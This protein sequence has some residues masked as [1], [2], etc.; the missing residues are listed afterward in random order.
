MIGLSFLVLIAAAGVVFTAVQLP[1]LLR[2]RIRVRAS[3]GCLTVLVL[4]VALPAFSGDFEPAGLGLL[5]WVFGPLAV[6]TKWRYEVEEDVDARQENDLPPLLRSRVLPSSVRPA[7]DLVWLLRYRRRVF[8][9]PWSRDR[10][11]GMSQPL[12]RRLMDTRTIADLQAAYEQQD[13]D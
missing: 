5:V 2:R 12:P 13:A 8:N 10:L 3:L 9:D 11:I 4:A 6:L 7:I 1:Y